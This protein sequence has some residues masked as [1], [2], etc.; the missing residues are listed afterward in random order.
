MSI[1]LQIALGLVGLGIVVLVHELGH[2]IAARL[3]NIKVD[4]F[5][6]GW[7]PKLFA[8]KIGET[9]YRLSAIP[10]G[11]YCKLHGEDAFRKAYEDDKKHIPKE[12]GSFFSAK[13]WKRIVVSAAGP[14]GNIVFAVLILTLTYMLGFSVEAADNRVVLVSDFDN[15]QNI[16]APA[17]EAGI[18]TGDKILEI[19]NSKVQNF[20]DIR[21]NI[22]TSGGD[23]Q[24]LLV[25]RDEKEFQTTIKPEFDPDTGAA[26]IGVAPWV[27]PV[28][29]SVQDGSIS[30]THGLRPG[31]KI[32]AI[33]DR[34]I[35]QW[36]EL[37]QALENIEGDFTIQFERNNTINE[38]R[39]EGETYS[40]KQVLGITPKYN[41]YSTGPYNPIKALVHGTVDTAEAFAMV[42]KGF[43]WLLTGRVNVQ[44]A[45]TGPIRMTPMIGQVALVS[46]QDG[47]SQ[48]FRQ[49]SHFIGFICAALAFMNLLPIPLLDGGQIVLCAFEIL[50]RKELTTKTVF[51][52]QAVGTIIVIALIVLVISNDI[53]NMVSDTIKATG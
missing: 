26:L 11:G 49:F 52:Y 25:Q 35:A 17:E 32:I 12:N 19:D 53:I 4:A 13:P 22:I 42:A 24:Q 48:G 45:V 5:S 20:Q 9:E 40:E 3:V 30:D 16:S 47:F 46:I 41:V 21:S 29:G 50:K 27:A 39:I 15:T 28:I 31:D 43:G 23:T 51:R 33:N 10:L 44:K 37:E 8:F 6:I 7:G 36:F 1:I 2:F 18:K 38:V 34:R 14:F